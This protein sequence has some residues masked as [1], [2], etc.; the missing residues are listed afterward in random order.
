MKRYKIGTIFLKN[1]PSEMAINPKDN[2][3]RN[4]QILNDEPLPVEGFLYKDRYN[5]SRVID[6][7]EPCG[8]CD[9]VF[10]LT[11]ID[12]K[13]AI[14]ST[15]HQGLLHEE[16][17]SL[18]KLDS[19]FTDIKSFFVTA[20]FLNLEGYRSVPLTK[21][22]SNYYRDNMPS[23]FHPL[24]NHHNKSNIIRTDDEKE[25]DK[26]TCNEIKN[27][28]FNSSFDH[29]DIII[30]YNDTHMLIHR[31]YF[32]APKSLTEQDGLI[33]IPKKYIDESSW[34]IANRRISIYS[35]PES[36][37]NDLELKVMDT[38]CG[39]RKSLR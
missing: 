35:D 20:E 11:H 32:D 36:I 23:Y 5:D 26:R 19:E 33:V 2:D 16:I 13:K 17:V 15:I 29:Q 38:T 34:S 21:G 6:P 12:D 24:S 9:C 39:S 10:K 28:Y 4:K 14:L 7:V 8:Y 37:I 30:C 3:Y 27:Q 31:T 1:I 25:L 22:D 18:D